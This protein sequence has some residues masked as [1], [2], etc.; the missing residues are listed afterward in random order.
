[1]LDRIFAAAIVESFRRAAKL[2][3]KKRMSAGQRASHM[4][5]WTCL[6]LKKAQTRTMWI[7]PT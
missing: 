1:M 6:P 2:M 5:M 3:A 4:V 7:S